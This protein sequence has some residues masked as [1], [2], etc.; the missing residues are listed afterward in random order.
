MA[1]L[2][3]SVDVSN[4]APRTESQLDACSVH[5]RMNVTRRKIAERQLIVRHLR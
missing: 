3:L 4:R 2:E 1:S 5:D